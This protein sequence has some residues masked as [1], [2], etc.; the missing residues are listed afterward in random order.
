MARRGRF[1]RREASPTA[2]EAKNTDVKHLKRLSRFKQ[3]DLPISQN[4]RV[5][6]CSVT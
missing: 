6:R 2:L 4:R 1:V 5:I 3:A